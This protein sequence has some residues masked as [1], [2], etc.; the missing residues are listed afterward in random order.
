VVYFEDILMYS[1]DKASHMEHL[2]QMFQVL[3]Q[4]KLYTKLE[5]CELFTPQV[6]F[7][8]HLMSS[9]GIQVDEFKVEAMKSWSTPTSITEVLSFHRLASFYRRF[10][11]D[12]SSIMAPLTK[13]MKKGNLEWTKVLQ[14]AI[15]II[16]ERLCSTPI[17]TLSNFDL[18]EIEC[19]ASSV[20]IEVVL[21]QAKRPLGLP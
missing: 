18:L 15:E 7:F 21:A 8:C 14:R 10:M 9:E 17:L 11:K 13:C 2:S 3:R 19:D 16:K 4:Q 12:F 1:R 20:A 6:I 5:K